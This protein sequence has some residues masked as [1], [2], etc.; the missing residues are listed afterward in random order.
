MWITLSIK[1]HFFT[2]KTN[3]FLELFNKVI[4]TLQ[5]GSTQN[6][7]QEAPKWCSKKISR[8][9]REAPWW[10]STRRRLAD[11]PL[12][13]H[14]L[15]PVHLLRFHRKPRRV[16][17]LATDP[18]VVSYSCCWGIFFISFPVRRISLSMIGR[19]S[20]LFRSCDSCMLFSENLL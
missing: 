7:P 15:Q 11:Y 5:N 9:P 12:S 20:V 17:L 18:V 6:K 2:I 1:K 13:H 16:L 10:F 14:H 4:C 19:N 8:T 3:N